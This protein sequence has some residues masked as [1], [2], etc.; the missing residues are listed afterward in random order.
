MRALAFER[1]F[2]G[3]YSYFTSFGYFSDEENERCSANVARALEPGGRLLLDMMNR[4]WLLTH[5][6]QRTWNQR[7][8]G[9]LLMEEIGARPADARA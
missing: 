6:Q 9:A 3:V 2:A 4:D 5:P 8:D 1:D 7:D